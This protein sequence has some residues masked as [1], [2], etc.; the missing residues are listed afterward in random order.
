MHGHKKIRI[1][2]IGDAC[3]LRERDERVIRARQKHLI[4]VLVA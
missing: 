2:L 4:P 1:R 3:A